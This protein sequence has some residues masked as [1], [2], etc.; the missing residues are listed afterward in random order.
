MPEKFKDR[1]E[2]VQ[3]NDFAVSPNE[4]FIA[5][6]YSNTE[7]YVYNWDGEELNHFTGHRRPISC[8]AFN[9]DSN[10]LAS[11]GQDNDIVVWDVVGDNGVCRLTGHQNAV[12]DLKFIEG[13]SWLVS[14]SKD[15]HIR[16]WDLDIQAC[17][18]TVT[19]AASEIYA[20]A[21]VGYNKVIA[22]GKS[23]DFFSFTIA[24][25][26]T[27]SSMNPVVLTLEAQIARASKHRVQ[28]I[29]ISNDLT[30]AAFVTTGQT[31][32]IWTVLTDEE[33]EKK[34]KRREKRAQKNGS[35]ATEVLPFEL[36][37][38]VS[39]PSKLCNCC[40]SNKQ[41]VATMADNSIVVLESSVAEGEE[42]AIFKQVHTTLSHNADIR[43]IAFFG[44][45]DDD[46]HSI[47]RVISAS[48]GSCRIWDLESMQCVQTIQCGLAT[49]LAV[50]PGGRFFIL[51]TR[52]GNIEM[53]DASLGQIYNVTKAHETRIWS[54]A[55]A[56]GCTEI[57]TGSGDKEVRFWNLGIKD[58]LPLLVHKKTLKL[59]DEVYSVCYSPDGKYVAAAL[60]DST[61]RIFETESLTFHISLYGAQLPVTSID[62]ST[63]GELIVTGSADKNLRIW[64]SEFGDCHR[65]LWAHENVVVGAKF[66]PDTH[67]AFTAGRDGVLKMWDCDAFKNVQ[68]LYSHIGEIYA[69]DVS[70]NGSYVV[71]GGRDKGIRI[72]HRTKESIYLSQ[73][74][75]K[76]LEQVLEADNAEKNDRT[77][78]AL[79][80][81]IFGGAVIDTPGRITAESIS[82]SDNLADAISGA[83]MVKL[84]LE[85]STKFDNYKDNELFRNTKAIIEQKR[86][87]PQAY[88]LERLKTINR[89]DIDVIMQS[90]PFSMITTLILFAKQ[91]LEEGKE[92]ELTVRVIVSLIKFHE[93][94][95]EASDNVKELF[96]EIRP[97]VHQKVNEMRSRCGS[98]LAALKII[99]REMANPF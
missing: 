47:D 98:N 56:P 32:D 37:Q 62:Y 29:Q 82:N 69:I 17:V 36:D 55:I 70:P 99:K 63:D 24:D 48:E 73:E 1:P 58:G 77:V 92:V 28:D 85:D 84:T 44:H 2:T 49:A 41:I 89:T 54:I 25:P 13:T 46:E 35:V 31:I 81:S 15:T 79:R 90:L 60:L 68:R 39:L 4:E 88:V 51:G 8:L 7:I 95:L 12:T 43:G 57:A 83:N 80:G 67:L 72:W 23:P 66:I 65:S 94:Q 75:E 11:G 50:L 40:F 18:Q 5:I 27:V 42:K 96:T 30:K 78:T 59:P 33:I 91:W 76:R 26:E 38:T 6:G 19:V 86:L 53:G 52:E 21:T 22:A 16:V 61:V 64:G 3:I 45:A 71:T 20:L 10:L 34:R 97:L 74:E 87:T 9:S 14:A 93:R